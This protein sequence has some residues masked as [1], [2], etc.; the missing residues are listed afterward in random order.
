VYRWLTENLPE[1]QRNTVVWRARKGDTPGWDIEYT[2]PAGERVAVEVKGTSGNSFPSLEITANEWESANRLRGLYRLCL[3]V[4]CLGAS[5]TLAWIDDPY[6]LHEQ[7][8]LGATPAQ[9]KLERI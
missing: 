3:V 1:T 8:H 2:G 9:W 4:S 7:G 5:P 6:G